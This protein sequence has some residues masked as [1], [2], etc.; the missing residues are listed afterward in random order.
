[1]TVDTPQHAGSPMQSA[2]L[3]PLTKPPLNSPLGQ[4]PL[5]RSQL[6]K[7][8]FVRRRSLL[9]PLPLPLAWFMRPGLNK[10]PPPPCF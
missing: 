10:H 1:M 4:E 2:T 7:K 3:W 6:Q 5:F 9:L 8:Q